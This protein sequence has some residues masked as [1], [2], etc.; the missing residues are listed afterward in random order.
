MLTMGALTLSPRV[1]T[2]VRTGG[3]S[4][5]ATEVTAPAGETA[6]AGGDEND[7]LGK[8]LSELWLNLKYNLTQPSGEATSE[9]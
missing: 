8:P 2:I 7:Q 1:T 6:T 9:K 5:R 4:V 3:R